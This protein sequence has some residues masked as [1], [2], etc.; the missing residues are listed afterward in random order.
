MNKDLEKRWL[1]KQAS[2]PESPSDVTLIERIDHFTWAWFVLPMGTG[3]IALLLGSQ[4]HTFRGLDTIGK[5]FFIVDLLIFVTLVGLIT[6]RFIR[7][8]SRL[9]RS[10]SNASESLFFPT[11]LISVSTIINLIW[12]YGGPSSSFWLVESVRIIFWIYYVAAFT[13]AVGQYWYLFKGVQFT[14]Q[15]MTP[16]WLLPVFPFML[17]GTVASDIAE[18]QPQ[19]HRLSICLGGFMAQGL[20]F[21]ISLVM[22]APWIRRMMQYGLPPPG[23]LHRSPYILSFDNSLD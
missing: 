15:G 7:Q 13:N 18:G 9:R 12:K 20:G 14:I 8:P 3:G 17:C 16:A 23:K 5:I 22:Y 21:L 19:E 2:Q 1:E 4:P 11:S 10:L 6:I